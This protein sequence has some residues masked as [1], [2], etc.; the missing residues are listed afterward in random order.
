MVPYCFYPYPAPSCRTDYHNA[1]CV[2]DDRTDRGHRSGMVPGGN[3]VPCGNQVPYGNLVP[4]GNLSPCLDL[5]ASCESPSYAPPF[6]CRLVGPDHLVYHA[7]GTFQTLPFLSHAFLLSYPPSAQYYLQIVPPFCLP[8]FPP[9]YH[10]SFLLF[11][12]PYQELKHK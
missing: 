7:G 3:R 9:S 8:F 4:C 10:L 12:T 1:P 5:R 2:D 6:P 11:Y